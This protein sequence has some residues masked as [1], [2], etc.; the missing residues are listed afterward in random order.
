MSRR[1][2]PPIPDGA[3]PGGGEGLRDRGRVHGVHPEPA[4]SERG[5]RGLPL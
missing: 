5:A 4:H 2:V 3:Q 1:L